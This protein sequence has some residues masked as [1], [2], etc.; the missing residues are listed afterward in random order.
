MT[1]TIRQNSNY[2]YVIKCKHPEFKEK[3]GVYICTDQTLFTVMNDMTAWANRE[4]DV[5]MLFEVE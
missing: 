4:L 3:W 2:N 1:A 5:E